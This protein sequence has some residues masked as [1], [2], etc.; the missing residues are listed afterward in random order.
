MRGEIAHLKKK[1]K[2]SKADVHYLTQLALENW[3]NELF[4]FHAAYEVTR[5][6]YKAIITL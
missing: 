6:P 3:D 1:K 4:L 5:S 2:I